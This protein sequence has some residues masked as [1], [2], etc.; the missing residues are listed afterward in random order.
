MYIFFDPHHYPCP[1]RPSEE[2]RLLPSP[3]CN[4]ELPTLA[5]SVETTWGA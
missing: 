4:K 1:Q 3:G 2:P 5:V